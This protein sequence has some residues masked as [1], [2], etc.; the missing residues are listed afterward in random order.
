MYELTAPDVFNI[1]AGLFNLF[2]NVSKNALIN[3]PT[4]FLSSPSGEFK[5]IQ[6]P[7]NK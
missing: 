7:T 4:F 6:C 3:S 2:L 5:L 1:S